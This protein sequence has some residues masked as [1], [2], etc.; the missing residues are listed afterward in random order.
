[1]GGG[2]GWVATLNLWLQGG[3]NRD[4]NL[5]AKHF[6]RLEAPLNPTYSHLPEKKR[7]RRLVNNP[8]F[9]IF[10]YGSPGM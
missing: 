8:V 3:V 1:M 5:N 2:W 9:E 10:Q 4:I 7:R 6:F